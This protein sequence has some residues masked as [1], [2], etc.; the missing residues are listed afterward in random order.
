MRRLLSGRMALVP[1]AALLLAASVIVP[2]RQPTPSQAQAAP[3]WTTIT[4]QQGLDGYDGT[5]DAALV[6]DSAQPTG[7][8]DTLP[9]AWRSAGVDEA[10]PIV[11]FD[12][13][14]IPTTATVS[15]AVLDLTVVL[16]DSQPMTVSVHPLLRLWDEANASWPEAFA[17][18]PW[19]QPGAGALGIDRGP[20]LEPVLTWHGSHSGLSIDV[21]TLV[22]QWVANPVNNFGVLLQAEGAVGTAAHV[23][24]AS[25]EAADISLRPRLTITYA[26]DPNDPT[27]TA[28]ATPTDTPPPTETPT[29]SPTPNPQQV[30]V[31]QRDLDGFQGFYDAT[32]SSSFPT[33]N[34]GGSSELA[35]N[36]ITYF[37]PPQIEGNSV[38]RIDMWDIPS[39]ATI[40]NAELSLYVQER[41]TAQAVTLRA[42]ELLRHWSEAQ[43][44]W[45]ESFDDQPWAVPGAAGANLDRAPLP[46]AEIN[47]D[48]TNG[49]VTIPLTSLVQLWV[50][51]P[52]QNHGFV[53][54]ITSEGYDNIGYT[55]ASSNNFDQRLRPRLTVQYSA[56]DSWQSAVFQ[57]GRDG[58]QQVADATINR[59]QPNSPLGNTFTLN[60]SWRDDMNDPAED[61]RALMRFWLAGVP[62][63]ATVQH[64]ELFLFI[65][66]APN[67]RPVQLQAWRML[68]H[69]SEQQ[70]TWLRANDNTPW[71]LPGADG[72]NLDRLGQADASTT[73]EQPEGWV[74]LDVTTLLQHQHARPEENFG[75]LLT[76]G[77]LNQRAAYYEAFSS[78]Y[79]EPNL[80]PLLRVRYTVDPTLPTLTP[81]PAPTY[82]P[83]QQVSLRQGQYGYTGTTDAGI[84]RWQPTINR[85]TSSRL[86]LGWRDEAITP[87]QDQRALMRF[88]L[89]AVSPTA[90]ISNA[91]LSLYVPY[92]RNPH[93][94]RLSAYRLLR[95]WWEHQATWNRTATNTPWAVPGGE[96]IDV[97]RLPDAEATTTFQ[98]PLGWVT[99]D[100]TALVQYFVNYP[101]EN[102]GFL[103]MIDGLNGQTVYYDIYSEN[104]WQPE[105]R[106]TLRFA[107][108]MD[109]A[110]PSPTPTAT[111]TATPTP[112][113]TSTPGIWR[114]VVLQQTTGGY[115]GTQ[116][117]QISVYAPNTNYGNDRNLDVRWSADRWPPMSDMKSLIQFDLN[118]IPPGAVIGEATLDL[119]QLGRS[120]STPMTLSVYRALRY[121]RELDVTWQ[122]A[123]VNAGNNLPWHV[124]GALGANIDREAEPLT[125]TVLSTANGWISIDVRDIVQLWVNQPHLN[126]G[127]IIEG[128]SDSY[129]DTVLYYFASRN[130]TL[131]RGR[132]PRLT[133]HYSA[134]PS[135]PTSTPTATPTAT[136][137]PS[138]TPTATPMATPIVDPNATT[139]AFQYGVRLYYGTR[140][141]W[142][143][144][145]NPTTNH[146]TEQYIKVGPTS[147][148][149]AARVLISYDLSSVPANAEVLGAWL[150]LYQSGRSNSTPLDV[151]VH[152]VRRPW[153]DGTATWYRALSSQFWQF[154]GASGDQDHNPAALDTLRLAQAIGWI[155]LDVTAAVREWMSYPSSNRGLILLSDAQHNVQYQFDSSERVWAGNN[156]TGGRPRLVITYRLP[157]P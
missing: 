66:P 74:A 121:W 142:I 152:Q 119:Y 153:T 8:T 2:V 55:F 65:P 46:S 48:S 136:P 109:P 120:N 35:V 114:T 124:P 37:Y 72:I 34:Y 110:F 27:A 137:L 131:D 81:T 14:S 22:Q 12:V 87:R 54:E 7:Q 88:D 139:V 36:W 5:L 143:G 100:V 141:T 106:P 44:N 125:Q 134:D 85:G 6:R 23:Q 145:S 144:A 9:L 95:P 154:P 60:L 84:T 4:L 135:V 89:A 58:Y 25:R 155:R 127:L 140:D 64:A 128:K 10:R 98:Q 73:F 53:L 40:E 39:E 97:D 67:S 45:T 99:L 26:S 83:W 77:G 133:V 13:T 92:S 86:L 101:Q 56:P 20:A 111:R 59:W 78:D 1:L 113:P 31:F 61:Q 126:R 71:T 63:Q 151:S 52:D 102:H 50:A 19:E 82:T 115:A 147:Q 112:T 68:R 69:W 75:F 91:Q 94:V 123:A 157:T 117:A 108:T 70:V 29:P 146:R 130:Y 96:G 93:A 118:P 43:T 47:L 33:T 129:Y 18:A 116:D 15:S 11:S 49:W 104:H 42:Y 3:L 103:L 148:G 80:R 107:Y 122:R 149:N 150:E 62:A 21:T 32:L 76:V 30:R 38:M 24:L 138:A 132:R 105:R 57:Y 51:Q 90:V 156:P 16:T 79:P 28:T 17:G 41:S